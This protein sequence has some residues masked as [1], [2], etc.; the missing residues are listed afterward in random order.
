MLFIAAPRARSTRGRWRH[1]SF[2]LETLTDAHAGYL[3]CYVEPACGDPSRTVLTLLESSPSMTLAY[4]NVLGVMN[5]YKYISLQ[6]RATMA[7]LS[8][9]P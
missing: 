3:G 7:H 5:W 1:A 2:H 6:V 9:L 4:C 8:H